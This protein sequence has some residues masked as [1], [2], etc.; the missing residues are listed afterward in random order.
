M[1]AAPDGAL[2]PLIDLCG[3]SS[4]EEVAAGGPYDAFGEVGVELALAVDASEDDKCD[5]EPVGA[6]LWHCMWM[7]C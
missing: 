5:E 4:E 6:G 7:N 2:H 1:F 3:D